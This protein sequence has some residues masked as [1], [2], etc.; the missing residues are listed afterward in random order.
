MDAGFGDGA[1]DKLLLSLA[2]IG[3]FLVLYRLLSV[4]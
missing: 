2:N 4:H 3:R 1:Y